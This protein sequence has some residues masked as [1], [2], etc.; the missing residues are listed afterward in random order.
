MSSKL[1]TLERLLV[2]ERQEL[3]TWLCAHHAVSPGVWVVTYRRVTG[4][5]RPSYDEIVD[6]LVSF[7]WI[8]GRLAKLDETRSML[9]CTPRNPRSHW[10]ASNKQRVA[11]LVEQG[12]M[13]PHGM[14][15]VAAAQANGAWDSLDAVEAM[16]MPPDF[17]SQ[18]AAM[19]EAKRNWE[20]FSASY[21][22]SI[23]YWIHT[24]KRAETRRS[25]VT[26]AV[27]ATAANVRLT[28]GTRA[29]SSGSAASDDARTP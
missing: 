17:E 3:R 27:A 23:L 29:A 25:R 26:A 21:R 1:D 2:Q 16:E 6:E 10:S 13:T 4:R 9:L 11:R 14:E 24:A 7:G 28:G 5:A 18:L 8:D 19:P 22:K 15:A 20:A 12:L